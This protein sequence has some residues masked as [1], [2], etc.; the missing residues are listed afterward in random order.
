MPRPALFTR[1]AVARLVGVAL[2]IAMTGWFAWGRG[3]GAV[4]EPMPDFA[5]LVPP[6]SPNSYIVRP[7]NFST[8]NSSTAAA[9][10]ESPVFAVP[11][12]TLEAVA[13]AVIRAQ[14]RVTEVAADLDARQYAFVQ[15]TAILRFPDTVTIRFFDLGDG[16]SSLAMFSRSKF[17]RSDLGVNRA[18]VE[19]WL[20]AIQPGLAQ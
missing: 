17:G 3:D 11:V 13:L 4:A 20:A 9:D 1:R 18:R 5:T 2:V 7:A 8:A 15:R 10:A 12:E 19:S 16:Q 14:P 6:S